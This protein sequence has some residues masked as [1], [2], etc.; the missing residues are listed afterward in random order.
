MVEEH[1][2]LKKIKNYRKTSAQTQSRHELEA[3]KIRT[4][5]A[6]PSTAMMTV[7]RPQT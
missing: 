2:S 1:P 5:H 3:T 6:D 7:S 4:H